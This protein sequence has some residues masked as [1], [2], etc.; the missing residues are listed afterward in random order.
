MYAE[1][2]QI[3]HRQLYRQMVTGLM[4]ILFLTVPVIPGLSGRQGILAVLSG[5]GI[6]L[7]LCTYFV[8]IKTV[9]QY[10]EK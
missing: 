1:N 10:P 2:A 4:G 9:F 5:T 3:S 7:I 8:R 6:Y